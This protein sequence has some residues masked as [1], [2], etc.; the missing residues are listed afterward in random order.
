MI[1]RSDDMGS[2]RWN[3]DYDPVAAI[4]DCPRLLGMDLRECGPNKLC[5]E[6][7]LDGEPHPWRKDKL[8]VFISRGAVWIMEEGGE[9]ISLQSWLKKYGGAADMK[10]A[11]RMIRGEDAPV[12]W[13]GPSLHGGEPKRKVVDPS[14]VEAARGYDLR[15]CPLFRWFCGLWSE[16]RV[17]EAWR[18]Y[19][20]TTDAEGLA[21]FWYV[22]GEGRVLHD[23]RVKYGEDG[24]RDKTFGGTREY[25]TKDGYSGRCFFGAH[26]V[27]DS[28]HV[29]VVESEKTAVAI[30]LEF[31][32]VA[33]ATAGKA[34]LKEKD[35][36]FI[37]YPDKDAYGEWAATGNRCV[38]WWEKWG[39]AENEQPST[40]D[41]LDM[42]EWKKRNGDEKLQDKR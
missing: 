16:D 33:V 20:V 27:P 24:H 11:L 23:K 29:Y 14:A 34:N 42:I 5:G 41:V 9:C 35:S 10:E 2:V 30:W 15:R 40:A 39:L 13:G 31:G 8:K 26:L 25:R 38:R 17:R 7:Y 12:R 32:R 3:F 28:G 1:Y 36:R 4:Q 6:Y 22:D 18:I 21:V 19:N 37:C